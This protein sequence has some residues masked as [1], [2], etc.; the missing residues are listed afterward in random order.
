MDRT[1]VIAGHTERGEDFLTRDGLGHEG[2]AHGFK[3]SGGSL[4][5]LFDLTQREREGGAFIPVFFTVRRVEREAHPLGCSAPVRPFR[6]GQAAHDQ[7][8]DEAD[9][10]RAVEPKPPRETLDE[11]ALEVDEPDVDR[12]TVDVRGT[13]T[14]AGPAVLRLIDVPRVVE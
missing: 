2:E 12:G 6:Q 8:D 5:I 4:D 9:V 7:L 3:F 13:V 10:D 1:P 11:V 14:V